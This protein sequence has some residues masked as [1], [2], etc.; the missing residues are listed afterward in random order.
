MPRTGAF[1][2]FILMHDAVHTYD[3][4]SQQFANDFAVHANILQTLLLRIN[5]SSYQ[6]IIAK[7]QQVSPIPLLTT[8]HMLTKSSAISFCVIHEITQFVNE[9]TAFI[10]LH[11]DHFVNFSYYCILVLL[12]SLRVE[13]EHSYFFFASRT[14][15]IRCVQATLECRSTCFLFQVLSATGRVQT[16]LQFTLK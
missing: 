8:N 11:F 9:V 12:F 14:F 2:K 1:S 7:Q 5:I 4:H 16:A 6:F 13:L 15:H 10:I 3:V